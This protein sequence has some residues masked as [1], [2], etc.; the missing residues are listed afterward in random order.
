MGRGFA[1]RVVLA[2]VVALCLPATAQA[3]WVSDCTPPMATVCGTTATMG[4]TASDPLVIDAS[5]PN[6]RHNQ[7]GDPGFQS[8]LDFDSD[9]T[10][11]QTFANLASNSIVA[12]GDQQP[13]TAQVGSA[14]VPASQILASFTFNAASGGFN[15]DIFTLENSADTAA[16]SYQVAPGQI[17][18]HG[19]GGVAYTSTST[20]D[21]NLT[22]NLKA[23]TAGDEISVQAD[24]SDDRVVDVDGGGGDDTVTLA[25][26]VDV[27]GYDGDLG[28]DTLS[29][30]G[31]ATAATFTLP[32]PTTSVENLVG[33]PAG[34][35]L[36][37][38][39]NANRIEGAG[40]AD[41]LSAAG[42]DD[43]LAAVDGAADASLDCGPGAADVANIDGGLDPAPTNCETVN[44][45]GGPPPDPDT[46]GDGVPDSADA[47]PATPGP[48]ENN[49]CPP[50]PPAA[51]R[52]G[53]GVA[54]TADRCPDVPGPPSGCP[55]VARR[56]TIDRTKH[57]FEGK[58]KAELDVLA[59]EEAQKVSVFRKKKGDDPKAGSDR[60]NTK[61]AF[62]V[63]GPVRDGK[64]YARVKESDE[65]PAAICLAAKSKNLTLD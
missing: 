33:G 51:D 45:V 3:D 32:G 26:G 44:S 28:T 5:G 63:D 38:D 47:C 23:G 22:V 60:T 16:R 24:N 15:T 31:H 39:G 41:T 40:G 34:D 10:L 11:E 49:G 13:D 42:G 12:F 46:D 1:P 64:Y 36:T 17:T 55:S 53:D 30:G 25:S 56:L 7:G 29:F 21:P 65:A 62:E 27:P 18:G 9:V 59:C 14:T 54:D 20:A 8:D 52:D 19:G 57:G 6:L 37:G 61:G 58:L 35:S 2:V 4:G 48:P 43:V 50:P